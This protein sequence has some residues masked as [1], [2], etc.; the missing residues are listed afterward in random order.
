MLCQL[1]SMA[2]GTQCAPVLDATA[3][4]MQVHTHDTKNIIIKNNIK[5][6]GRVLI[7]HQ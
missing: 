4:W 5:N 6:Y 3:I 7:F 2:I 1:V